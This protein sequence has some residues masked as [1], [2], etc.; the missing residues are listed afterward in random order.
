M[1]R[2]KHHGIRAKLVMC[3]VIFTVF[4][5]LVL[6][7]LQIRM[8]GY[9]YEQEK[10]SELEKSCENVVVHLQ[11]DNLKDQIAVIAEE[12]GICIRVF[13]VSGTNRKEIA[14]AAI[15]T[16]CMI[17]HLSYDL[18]AD[19][20]GRAVENDGV[21]DKRMQFNKELLEEEEGDFRLPGLH[22][23]GNTTN[24]IYVRVVD[25]GASQYLI[26]LDSE[27]SPLGTTVNTL[28]VQFLWIAFFLLVG[29]VILALALSRLVAAPLTTITSKA[30]KLAT[31]N[32][33]ANFEG[34][35]YREV[36]E[37][38]NALNFAAKEIGT[39]DRLQKELIANI[40][41][42]LR[43]P[44]TMIKGYSEMMRDLPGENNAENAQII[45]DETTRLSQLVSD[46]MDL[47]KL[48][49]GAKK[50]DLEVLDLVTLL[51]ETMKRY[52][53]LVRRDGYRI[54]L[55]L[56]EG[57]A[58]VLADRSIL[59]QVIYNLI[60]NAINYTGDSLRVRVTLALQKDCARVAVADDG[61]GIPPDK[62]DSIWDRYYR[63]DTVH[64][65][66]VMG[67]GIGLSIVKQALE[68]HN[69]KY[70]V[71]SAVGV[72]SIF[73]FEIPLVQEEKEK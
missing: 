58:L 45:I 36:E 10:F 55:N 52:E 2:S 66:A 21:Y 14:D 42:D 27:L 4:I 71:E 11:D 8:L 9:F 69:A 16:D 13:S 39:T 65:R 26:L 72:G 57:E 1:S 33:T 23:P 22:V 29:A 28:Q 19:L 3:L 51:S 61:E 56:P 12:M 43:T 25:V 38:A 67:T 62:I 35:G 68:A 53:S 15:N 5:L 30:E 64:K 50:A 37:L 48:Q 20:Y 7:L 44:L 24:A 41:H 54:E 70:G 40:S 34:K 46:L 49:S 18:I 63:V 6:W 17:H 59:L 32:Y 47:S 31:G 73:W 60:N